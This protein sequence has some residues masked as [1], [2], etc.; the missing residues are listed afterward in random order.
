MLEPSGVSVYVTVIT[1]VICGLGMSYWNYKRRAAYR[2]SHM[3]NSVPIPA[4]S[5]Y[6]HRAPGTFAWAA[7]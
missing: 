3:P 7:V 5:A 2:P 1:T 4:P 6:A